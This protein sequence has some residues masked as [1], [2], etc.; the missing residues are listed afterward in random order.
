M[1]RFL[2]NRQCLTIALSSAYRSF[3][4]DQNNGGLTGTGDANHCV[5]PWEKRK[6]KWGEAPMGFTPALLDNPIAGL[7]LP[8]VFVLILG[9]SILALIAHFHPSSKTVADA[10]IKVRHGAARQRGTRRASS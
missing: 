3:A 9:L 8:L 5:T 4:F 6:I 1:A 2:A 7:I 10:G